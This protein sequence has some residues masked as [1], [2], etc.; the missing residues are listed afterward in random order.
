[1]S[2]RAARPALLPSKVAV[3]GFARSGRALAGALVERGVEVAVADDRPPSAFEDVSALEARG[4][5]FYFSGEGS[6]PLRGSDPILAGAG[7]LAL[8]PGVPTRHPLVVE[9]RGRGASGT[10]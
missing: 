5:R 9:A 3:L 1:M 7:W 6:D 2:A 10:R 8:S 4:A